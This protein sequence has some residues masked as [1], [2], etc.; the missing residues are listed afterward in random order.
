VA[1]GRS[2]PRRL[3]KRVLRR[4]RGIRPLPQTIDQTDYF[5]AADRLDRLAALI[6]VYCWLLMWLT[7]ASQPVF[8]LGAIPDE[9]WDMKLLIRA[10]RP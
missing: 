6:N 1:A 4:L 3:A 2:A 10:H 5:A 9:V 8:R 7:G